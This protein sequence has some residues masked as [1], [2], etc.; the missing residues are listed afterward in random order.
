MKSC[1]ICGELVG[2]SAKSCFN[3][4]YN[5]ELKRKVTNEEA[6]KLQE[7]QEKEQAKKREK[8]AKE[9]EEQ[10]EQL[11]AQREQLLKNNSLF[12]YQVVIVNNLSTGEVNNLAIQMY[13]NKFSNRGWR[14]HSVFNNEL[15]KTSSSVAVGFVG[16][17]VNATIDQT[18]LIFER[19]V[20][21][22]TN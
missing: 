3:C 14:L 2:D 20:Q 19:C 16:S 8:Q 17:S 18:V 11:K 22:K 9:Q 1:P 15:G 7:E 21:S 13:L 10:E 6:R 12:E 4:Q 5:F